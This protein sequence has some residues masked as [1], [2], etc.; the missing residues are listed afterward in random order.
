MFVNR[1]KNPDRNLL[2]RPCGNTRSR[3][4]RRFWFGSCFRNT[5]P[6]GRRGDSCCQESAAGF[7]EEFTTIDRVLLRTGIHSAHPVG[8][9]VSVTGEEI[10]RLFAR[11]ASA[12]MP[13]ENPFSRLELSAAKTLGRLRL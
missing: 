1:V 9:Q 7:R 11:G 8:L 3:D 6:G 5:H 13:V 4:R 12:E 2:L 10:I